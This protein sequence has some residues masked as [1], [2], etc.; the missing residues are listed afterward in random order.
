MDQMLPYKEWLEQQD[1]L[2]TKF[3]DWIAHYSY[4]QDNKTKLWSYWDNGLMPKREY[5]TK[6]LFNLFKKETNEKRL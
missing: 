1:T 4:D 3:A 2:A 5:T 6:E